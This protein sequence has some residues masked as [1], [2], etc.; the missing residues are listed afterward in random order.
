MVKYVICGVPKSGKSTLADKFEKQGMSVF[1]TDSIK[2]EDWT[3]Q[4]EIIAD[5]IDADRY[6]VI[7]GVGAVR[8]LRSFLKHH[9][10]DKPCNTVIWLNSSNGPLTEKQRAMAKGCNT[11]FAG[12]RHELVARGVLISR[13]G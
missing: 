8:G 13:G 7:E 1:H 3:K 5:H 4:T 6:D 12:I 11:I 10:K 9:P 2:D